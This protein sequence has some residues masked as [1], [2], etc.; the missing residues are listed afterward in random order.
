MRR[1]KSPIYIGM[2]GITLRSADYYD[3]SVILVILNLF[4]DLSAH[5]VF[6]KMKLPIRL[7]PSMPLISSLL[8]SR[9]YSGLLRPRLRQQLFSNFHSPPFHSGLCYYRSGRCPFG[10]DEDL[11][12]PQSPNGTTCKSAGCNEMKP[13]GN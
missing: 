10:A 8:N 4:Q 1:R 13:C 5:S 6:C 3:W 9:F 12:H 2:T 7:L 11:A